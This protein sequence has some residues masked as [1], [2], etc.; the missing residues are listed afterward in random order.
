MTTAT[1]TLHP[2]KF[3]DPIIDTIRGMLDAHEVSG[4]ILDPLAGVGGVHKLASPKRRTLGIEIEPE[5]A[6]QHPLTVCDDAFN[7]EAVLA[8]RGIKEVD[9]IVVSP[10][11][12]NRLADQ[13]VPPDTDKSKRFTYRLSLDRELSDNNVAKFHFGSDEYASF[14]RELWAKCSEVLKV[15]GLFILN[16]SDFVRAGERVPVCGFHTAVL[17]D[18]GLGV[19][20]VMPVRTRRM[21][22]GANAAARVSAEMVMVFQ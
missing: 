9:A 3:S 14:H 13:Y 22:F 6:N 16:V 10:P 12:G 15:G 21:K 17:N 7:M 8:A 1:P 5:W 11:Y 20:D 18:L 19:I 2:A 4:L